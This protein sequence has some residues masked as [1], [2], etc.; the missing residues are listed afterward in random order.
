MD[1]QDR[2]RS[3]AARRHGP[4]VAPAVLHVAEPGALSSVP[5]VQPGHPAVDV[6]AVPLA[7][8]PRKDG[9]LMEPHER[10]DWQGHHRDVEQKSAAAKDQGL[11]ED[12]RGQRQY[13]GLRI[14]CTPRRRP[15]RSAAPSALGC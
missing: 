4:Q 1:R 13:M 2:G 6:R 15:G 11:P 12:R 10:R 8:G 5:R 3:G 14:S 7:E 9:L